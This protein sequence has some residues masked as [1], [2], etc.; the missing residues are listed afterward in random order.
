MAVIVEGVDMS[1][2]IKSRDSQSGSEDRQPLSR[3]MIS[4]NRCPE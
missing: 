3:A 1:C 2:L 4:N